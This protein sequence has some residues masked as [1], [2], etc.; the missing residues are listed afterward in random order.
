[1]HSVTS[2]LRLGKTSDSQAEKE[3]SSNQGWSTSDKG[4]WH[5]TSNKR[6][7]ELTTSS[8]PFLVSLENVLAT[9]DAQGLQS[10]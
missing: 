1:M 6:Q 10:N 7:E 9:G 3:P 8:A 5:V 4:M 2:L